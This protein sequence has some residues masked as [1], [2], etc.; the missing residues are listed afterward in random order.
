MSSIIDLTEGKLKEQIIF[1]NDKKDTSLLNCINRFLLYDAKEVRISNDFA[2]RS[3]YFC[4]INEDES[5][6]MNGG[7]IYHG[8]HDNGGDGGSPTFSVSLTPTKGWAIHT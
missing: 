2:P 8:T 6:G 3:F 5:Q 1:A 4:L 7:I